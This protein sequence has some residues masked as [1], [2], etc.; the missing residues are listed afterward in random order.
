VR[1]AIEHL[2]VR[3]FNVVADL[4]GRKERVVSGT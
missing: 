4:I 1:V 2:A 3:N